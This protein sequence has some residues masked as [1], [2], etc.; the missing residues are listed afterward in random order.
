MF[1]A[2]LSWKSLLVVLLSFAFLGAAVPNLVGENPPKSPVLK[3]KVFRLKYC[4]PSEIMEILNGLIDENDP[5]PPPLPMNFQQPMGGAL[6]IGGGIG[7]IGGMTG[8][9]GNP[10]GPQNS[11]TVDTRTRSLVV[12]LSDKNL[13]LATDLVASLDLPKDKPLPEVKSLKVFQ[14]KHADAEDLLKVLQE[15]NQDVK[16]MALG[17]AK[18]VIVASSEAVMKEIAELVKDL[19][20]EAVPEPKPE[21]QRK[22]LKEGKGM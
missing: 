8:F 13:Q 14:L 16:M 15:V 1:R 4:D 11:V 22:L 19:D 3:A 17:E 12:R 9:G 2:L 18:M 20:V 5:P 10:L 21:E 7:G 6:G